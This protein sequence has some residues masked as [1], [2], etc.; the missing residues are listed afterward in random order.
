MEAVGWDVVSAAWWDMVGD[1]R[2]YVVGAVWWDAVAVAR[3]DVWELHGGI[4]RELCSGMQWQLHGRMRWEMHGESQW[5]ACGGTWRDL[6][7]LARVLPGLQGPMRMQVSL[8]KSGTPVHPS[9][10]PKSPQICR[11]PTWAPTSIT[12]GP[13]DP[14]CPRQAPWAAEGADSALPPFLWAESSVLPRQKRGQ[15]P[16]PAAPSCLLSAMA[17]PRPGPAATLLP[18]ESLW[19]TMACFYGNYEHGKNKCMHL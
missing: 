14:P 16:A 12:P 3:W 5:K 18:K 15:P 13:G 10:H 11:D 2:R 19:D 9:I 8:Y 17:P 7:G 6:H 1:A 4:W